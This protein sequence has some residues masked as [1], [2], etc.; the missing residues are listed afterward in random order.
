MD[1]VIVDSN[2]MHRLAWEEY[3]RRHG[4]ETTEEMHRRMYG[5]RN[6]SIVRDFYGADLPEGQV[7]AH[8]AAKEAL[9]RE[10]IGPRL[11][12][13]LVPGIR[14]F[15]KL[16]EN[17]PKAVATNAEPANM[18]FVLDGAALRPFFRAAIDGH[19]VTNPKPH[20]EVFLRAAE[21][22]GFAPEHCLVFEDSHAGVQAALAAD[23]Q[24]IGITTTHSDLRGVALAV[25]DFR[26]SE[27]RDWIAENL[28]Q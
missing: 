25:P 23:M 8:G 17:V 1:G 11:E 5:R 12:S 6:D 19:Q 20:P 3:N 24:A 13:A 4:I 28:I 22:L 15:L 7:F 16:Y 21:A 27:L 10:M 26:S 14:E 9:Y 2:P 18:N